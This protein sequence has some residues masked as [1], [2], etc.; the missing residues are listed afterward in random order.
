MPPLKR[1]LFD[2][3][4]RK[5]QSE[6][7]CTLPPKLGGDLDYFF[8]NQVTLRYPILNN[9]Q[10]LNGTQSQISDLDWISSNH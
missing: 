3:N 10:R 9:I 4:L 2:L 1:L 5:K 8:T 6:I 7:I